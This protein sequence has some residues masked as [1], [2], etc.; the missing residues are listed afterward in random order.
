[1][2]APGG[3]PGTGIRPEDAP[4]L[5]GP[6]VVQEGRRQGQRDLRAALRVG[7][8]QQ[9]VALRLVEKLPVEVGGERGETHLLGA[10]RRLAL[11]PVHGYRFSM[12]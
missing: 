6:V 10:L 7:A 5:L 4:R 12:A 8:G 2:T 9:G 11:L 3:S 1:M